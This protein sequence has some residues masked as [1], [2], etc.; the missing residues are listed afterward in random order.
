MILIVPFLVWSFMA[1]MD[2]KENNVR[3]E[4]FDNYGNTMY[5]EIKHK[6]KVPDLMVKYNGKCVF[7]NV[8]NEVINE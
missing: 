6:I 8:T 5:N 2:E 3:V 4:C 7:G 1:I